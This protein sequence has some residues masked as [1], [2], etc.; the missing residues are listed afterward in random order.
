VTPGRDYACAPPVSAPELGGPRYVG[1]ARIKAVGTNTPSPVRAST[2]EAMTATGGQ[3]RYGVRYL[4][5]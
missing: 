4:S 3:V 5:S 1:S 2:A